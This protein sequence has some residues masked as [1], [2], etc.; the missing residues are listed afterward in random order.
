MLKRNCSHLYRTETLQQSG[1]LFIGTFISEIL[2]ELRYNLNYVLAEIGLLSDINIILEQPQL[3]LTL[4]AVW[5]NIQRK[6]WPVGE[7][8]LFSSFH[9]RDERKDVSVE[10]WAHASLTAGKTHT[11]RT[12]TAAGQTP[13]NPHSH[14]YIQAITQTPVCVV[15]VHVHPRWCV[16]VCLHARKLVFTRQ[17]LSTVFRSIHLKR[18]TC[19]CL[20]CWSDDVAA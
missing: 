14:C 7:K 2:H 1:L 18:C 4:Q 16:G 19:K 9:Q 13:A 12:P 17:K 5:G 8:V 15:P 3:H 6:A 20:L 10:T 11:H